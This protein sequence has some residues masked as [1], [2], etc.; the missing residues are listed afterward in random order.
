MIARNDTRRTLLPHLPQILAYE[1]LAL[2]HVLL[3]ERFLARGYVEAWRLRRTVRARH[4]PPRAR[5]PFG[6]EPE[7]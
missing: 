3:R 1:V 7:R 4:V 2:G 6:L 5:V